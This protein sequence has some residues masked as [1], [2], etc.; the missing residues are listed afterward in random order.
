MV[1][2]FKVFLAIHIMGGLLGLSTGI[3]IMI[4]KKGNKRHRKLGKVFSVAMMATGLSSLVLSVLH[5]SQFMFMVGVF[6][7][8]MVGTGNRY[9]KLKLLN[10]HQKPKMIDWILSGIMLLSGLLFLLLGIRNLMYS[11]YFGFVF[12]LFGF[13]GLQ[14]VRNDYRNYQGKA[15]A[16]N[17]WLSEHIQR[18]TGAFIA[19][20]TAFLVVNAKYLPEFIPIMVYWLLPTFILTPLII[21]WTNQYTV[22]KKS[23]KT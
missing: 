13:L 12:L 14:Y 21:K 2:I 20:S 10:K 19:S 23:A 15:K 18:M 11:N 1:I 22:Q 7:V 3:W 5:P 17:Y 9:L 4:G 6:T 16:L 8:Y